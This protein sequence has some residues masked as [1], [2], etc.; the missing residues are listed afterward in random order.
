MPTTSW[1]KADIGGKIMIGLGGLALSV[2]LGWGEYQERKTERLRKEAEDQHSLEKSY[3]E[4]FQTYYKLAHDAKPGDTVVSA[5]VDLA[6]SIAQK[7]ASPPFNKDF[8]NNAIISLRGRLSPNSDTN[9]TKKSAA[10]VQAA[11]AVSPDVPRNLDRWF[12]VI[13][14]Y[15]VSRSGLAAARKQA[16]VAGTRVGCA[17][18]WRTKISN[19][20]AVV[21]GG[22]ANQASAL[23]N[24]ER[25]RSS[26]WGDAFTQ[27]DRE[28]SR[29]NGIAY[30]CP[31]Q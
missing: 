12:A 3:T 7:L 18:V 20:Y 15:P 22:A 31:G 13:A 9:G 14:S 5:D 30:G 26:G 10:Q 19:N 27:A 21:V 17:Q 16:E 25:S 23:V 6:G 29:V 2:V 8:Y 4:E 1:D 24:A 11:E 28:W